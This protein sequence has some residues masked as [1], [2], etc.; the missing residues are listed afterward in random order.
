ME[1][2]HANLSKARCRVVMWTL[3]S[4]SMIAV[5]GISLGCT[6]YYFYIEPRN[7]YVEE[8]RPTMCT[9][10]GY[11][12]DVSER[13]TNYGVTYDSLL[14]VVVTYAYSD[15]GMNY[16]TTSSYYFNSVSYLESDPNVLA[17]SLG[18]PL[19]RAVIRCYYQQDNPSFVSPILT[20]NF[21]VPTNPNG[22]LFAILITLGIIV[23]MSFV[24]FEVCVSRDRWTPDANFWRWTGVL[25]AYYEARW[26]Y[27]EAVLR[28]AT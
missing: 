4:L 5:V 9:V 14:Y 17:V 19:I 21:T 25:N 16:T 20:P 12:V 23:V 11:E 26:K 28:E 15:E 2:A 7:H 18:A 22:T 3:I 13:D 24:A 27:A 8:A 10:N 6:W 1:Q